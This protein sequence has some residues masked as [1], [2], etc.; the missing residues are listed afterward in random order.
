VRKILK[1]CWYCIKHAWRGCWTRANEQAGLF[2]GA[3]LAV[4]LYFFPPRFAGHGMIMAPETIWGTAALTVLLAA[5]SVIL[6]F[7]IIFT[8]RL[9]LAP[10]RLYW[11]QRE[12][13]NNLDTELR[14]AQKQRDAD[15]TKWTIRELFQHIDPDFLEDDR[16]ETI[17]D[18]LRDALSTGRLC[19]W[20]RLKETDSGSWVGPRAALKPIEES[21][22]YTAYFTYFFFHERTSD[23]VHCYADRKTGRPAYTDLQVSRSETLAVWPGEPG[24]IADSYPNVRVADSPAVIDLFHG[25]ERTKLIALLAAEKLSTWAR[26]GTG[27]A[28]D[29]VKRDGEIWNNHSFQFHPKGDGAGTI[30]QTFLRPNHPLEHVSYYDVCF[31]FAQ[32]RRVWPTLSISRTKCDIR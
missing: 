26:R 13:A 23:D 1:F 9:V 14:I 12:R 6:A 4:L 3:V 28:N 11:E 30:N 21:Y 16:Y 2:G 20:G 8:T 15:D 19:M 27:V 22:W 24:D 7:L 31:N 5:G 32:L 18:E 25:R 17:A 29:L 10:A